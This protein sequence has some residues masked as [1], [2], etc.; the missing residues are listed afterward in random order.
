MLRLEDLG[1][2][3]LVHSGGRV[4]FYVKSSCD[5]IYK[6]FQKSFLLFISMETTTASDVVDEHNEIGCITFGAVLMYAD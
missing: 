4:T 3:E 5:Q 1:S 6:P 2:H